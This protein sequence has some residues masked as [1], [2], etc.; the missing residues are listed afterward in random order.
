MPAAEPLTSDPNAIV[1][2][3]LDWNVFEAL[4]RGE[5]RQAEVRLSLLIGRGRVSV[6]F[7]AAHVGEL[8]RYFPGKHPSTDPELSARLDWLGAFT[9]DVYLYD[10]LGV[11]RPTLRRESPR[12]VYATIN[13]VPW[14][15]DEMERLLSLVDSRLVGAY[16]ASTGLDPVQVSNIRP[17]N[18]IAQIDAALRE[19]ARIVPAMAGTP[20]SIAAMLQAARDVHPRGQTFGLSE[21]FAALFMLLNIIG[22]RPDRGFATGRRR[23]A[24][25]DA[26]H[27]YLASGADCFVTDDARLRIK[28]LAAYEYFGIPTSV[29]ALDELESWLIN[30]FGTDSPA[31]AGE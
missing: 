21:D 7:S 28:A 13:D 8:Q 17:P 24:A 1:G 4:R 9:Q 20:V 2:I 6:P 25:S 29:Q 16:R 15:D 5:A 11:P 26:E 22:F 12:A 19:K 30:Q 31:T 14:A 23:A 10:G 18:V 27:A 3:Y